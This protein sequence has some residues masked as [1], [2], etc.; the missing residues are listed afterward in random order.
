VSHECGGPPLA[1]RIQCGTKTVTYTGDTEWTQN[2]VPAATGVDLLIAEAY[3]F[4]KKVRYHFDFRTLTD[5]MNEL[6]PRRLMIMH[7]SSDM[8]DRLQTLHCEYAEDGKVVRL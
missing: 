2:L 6:R 5:H 3:Y 8:L 7:M 4:E 1:L